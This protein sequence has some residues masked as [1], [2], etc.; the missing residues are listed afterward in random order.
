MLEYITKSKFIMNQNIN[1]IKKTTY[2]CD[3][4]SYHKFIPTVFYSFANFI[5]IA[6]LA[7]L[8]IKFVGERKTCVG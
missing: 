7:R 8:T 5:L 4:E 6:K 2:I 1:Y 3:R